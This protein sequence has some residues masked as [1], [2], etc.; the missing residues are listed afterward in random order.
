MLFRSWIL[1]VFLLT[2]SI[3][4]SAHAYP[5]GGTIEEDSERNVR[6]F[7]NTNLTLGG[8]FASS[9][10]GE[11]QENQ[12][13]H[14]ASSVNT[15][16]LNLGA[17]FSDS[18]AFNSQIINYMIL[19]PQNPENDPQYQGFFPAHN[20]PQSFQMATAVTQ[21]Y[22]E[23]SAGD[24][25]AV[26]FGLGYAPFGIALQLF[27]PVLFV[28]RGGPQFLTNNVLVVPTWDGL[29]A[30]GQ[31]PVSSTA[32][33]YDVYTFSSNF[34]PNSLGMGERLWWRSEDDKFRYGISNLTGKRGF[35]T[36]DSVGMD[37]RV[38]SGNLT[39]TA[40]AVKSLG[41]GTQPWS[42]YVEPDYST[43]RDTLILFVFG[44]YLLDPLASI[45]P[46]SQV[47][48]GPYQKWEYG[49]GVNWLPNVFT[50]FRLSFTLNDYIGSSAAVHANYESLDLS[51][52]VSF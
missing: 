3:S 1:A 12:N 17:E 6:S 39:L 10:T 35:T 49:A 8:F 14:S 38:I 52:G 41:E 29:R 34:N 51:V 22:V 48:S 16:G 21:A 47:I 2:F 13:L 46:T 9:L 30:H 24:N 19:P 7:L 40:E 31:F 5:P 45:A 43:A 36:F 32:F 27:E 37:L 11:K 25:F 15:F 33:H 26:D 42:F 28:R 4:H 18:L 20:Q 50:R 44:D 23:W